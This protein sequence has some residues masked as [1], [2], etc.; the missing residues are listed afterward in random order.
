MSRL[1]SRYKRSCGRGL[2]G[3]STGGATAGHLARV[4][5]CAYPPPR[6][7]GALP[8][9][10]GY[11]YV[12]PHNPLIAMYAEIVAAIQSAK[13]AA[14]IA[15]AAT[16]LSNYNELVAALS[17]VNS[18]LME[19]TAVALSSQEKHS[20]LLQQISALKAEVAELRD[21]AKR[22]SRYQ[23]HAFPTGALVHALREGQEDGEPTHY[24]CTACADR[25][26]FTRLQPTH[27]KRRLWCPECKV[28]LVA[29]YDPP[30]P[31]QQRRASHWSG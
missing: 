17:E 7:Q 8:R 16:S 26:K 27:G 11:L 30:S 20:E 1:A 19:A 25:S 14:D 5:Q 28:T 31:P 29:E 24:L 18:K 9:P 2:T 12:R 21:I 4:T 13:T 10:P 23:L 6:G 22:S 15:R 3:Q